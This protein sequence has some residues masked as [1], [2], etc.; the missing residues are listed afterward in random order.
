MS[1]NIEDL[2]PET[3]ELY[4][5]FDAE[6]KKAGLDYIV[7]CTYRSQAE[8][9]NLYKQGRTSA[10]KIVTW[11]KH[12]KHTDRIA[13]DIVML[14]NGKVDWKNIEL[15]KKAGEIGKSVGLKWGGDWKIPDYPHFEKEA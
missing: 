15:Y 6:M 10:G 2:T 5:K 11:T 13:F 8:Q 1:R 7:T 9:D 12:S 3:Q 4:W 14:N